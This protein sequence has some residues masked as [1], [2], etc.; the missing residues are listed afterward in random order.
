MIRLLY[1]GGIAPVGVG[2]G[3]F[4]HGEFVLETFI[5]ACIVSWVI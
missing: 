2:S 5:I 3:L 4:T 1:G